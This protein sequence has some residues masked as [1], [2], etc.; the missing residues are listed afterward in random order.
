VGEKETMSGA[1]MREAGTGMASG[2][3]ASTGMATGREASTPSVSEREASSG[4][5]TGRTDGGV[6]HEDTWDRQSRVAT[7]DVTG[8]GAAGRLNALPPGEPVPST[9]EV[10]T[11]DV[12]GDG[13]AEAAVVKSKSNITNN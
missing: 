8:D 1:D 7:G 6:T 3:E 10:A 13:A 12:T 2:R 5:A 9:I 11:G 4:Q